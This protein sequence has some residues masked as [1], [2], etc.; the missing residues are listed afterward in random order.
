M[1]RDPLDG[2]RILLPHL[3]PTAQG[4]SRGLQVV[5]SVTCDTHTRQATTVTH[6]AGPVTCDRL[7]H[8]RVMHDRSDKM[9]QYDIRQ[10]IE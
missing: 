2:L 9:T 10:V 6:A 8:D 3:L 4:L 1:V 7:G 5:D